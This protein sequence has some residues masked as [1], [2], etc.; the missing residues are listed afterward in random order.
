M[1][2]TPCDLL[3]PPQPRLGRGCAPAWVRVG[4]GGFT[5]VELLLIVAISGVLIGVL[6]PAMAR[7]RE[8]SRANACLN[9]LKQLGVAAELYA[10][11]NGG[12][13]AGNQRQDL[14]TNQWVSGSM[15]NSQD[16]TNVSL[17]QQ[18]KFFPYVQQPGAF[19]C[20]A[21]GEAGGARVR[22]YA[23]NSWIGSRFM[24]AYPRLTGYRTFIKEAE[25]APTGAAALWYLAEE[26]AATLDDGWFLVTMD[27]SRPFASL[28]AARHQRGYA[29]QFADGHVATMKLREAE[30]QETSMPPSARNGDWLQL[31]QMTTVQ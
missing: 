8:R 19:H 24:E 20:P 27:D 15:M 11:D 13:L 12:L 30:T 23:M 9:N 2:R 6:L 3:R 18:S 14:G 1:K 28:P 31:K 26:H 10:A 5:L 22:S 29:L 16:A 21:D 17:V 7:S 25:F 4:G